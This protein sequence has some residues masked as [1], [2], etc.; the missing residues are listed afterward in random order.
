M[1]AES[2]KRPGCETVVRVSREQAAV[3]APCCVAV[4]ADGQLAASGCSRGELRVWRLGSPAVISALPAHARSVT[5][6]AFAPSNLLLLSA[7]DDTTVCVWVLPDCTRTLTYKVI[8]F[9]FT[10]F[11]FRTYHS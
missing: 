7:S 6:V 1:G 2:E 11:F 3:L 10:S 8:Q 9:Y 4:S 5:C